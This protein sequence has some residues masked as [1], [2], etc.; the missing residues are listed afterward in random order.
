MDFVRGLAS[1]LN[2]RLVDAVLD[3]LERENE[4]DDGP[5]IDAH[6]K[7]PLTFPSLHRGK[8]PDRGERSSVTF[9]FGCAVTITPAW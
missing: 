2:R 8:N 5:G 1:L 7:P 9:P 3:L 4:L 6:I